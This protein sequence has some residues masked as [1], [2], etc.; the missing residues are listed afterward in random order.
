M[1]IGALALSTT[2]IIAGQK[3]YAANYKAIVDAL[4]AWAADEVV[5]KAIDNDTAQAVAGV[6]TFSSFPVTPSSAPSTNYQVA[7]KKYAD[8]A[9]AAKMTPASYAGEE[10][11]TFPNGL[12]L[13][14][15]FITRTGNDTVVTF[16]TAFPTGLISVIF[17]PKSSDDSQLTPSYH[18]DTVT[19]FTI[20]GTEAAWSGYSWQA[21]GR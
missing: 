10:S 9:P 8:D 19:G 20:N 12:I 2:D 4:N 21:W 3:L 14:H 15:G 11:I 7:N 1:A 16:G 5:T 17:S 18:T 13:K 6:K